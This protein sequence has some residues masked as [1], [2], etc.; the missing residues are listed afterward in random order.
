MNEWYNTNNITS[1]SYMCG[2]CGNQIASEKG[3]FTKDGFGYIFAINVINL[4]FLIVIIIRH[5]ERYMVKILQLIYQKI[6]NNCIMKQES[7][8]V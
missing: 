2:F 3:Y 5:Q 7:A 1:K 8:L 6:Y 4:L